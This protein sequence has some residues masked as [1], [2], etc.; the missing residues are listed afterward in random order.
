MRVEVWKSKEPTKQ[1]EQ[2]VIVQ[3]TGFSGMADLR[4]VNDNGSPRTFGLLA[5]LTPMGMKLAESVNPNLG[6]P[7]DKYGRIKIVE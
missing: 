7:L 1:P 4:A 3:L 5:T 2:V 6:F